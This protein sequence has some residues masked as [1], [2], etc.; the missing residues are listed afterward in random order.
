MG[1]KGE[2]GRKHWQ[3]TMV[4]YVKVT[5]VNSFRTSTSFTLRFS[6]LKEVHKL[7]R[8]T[9]E[10]TLVRLKNK[11]TKVPG[12]NFVRQTLVSSNKTHQCRSNPNK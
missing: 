7:S 2:G 3:A 12:L 9:T 4:S 1:K 11:I 5:N 6:P 8:S 10:C